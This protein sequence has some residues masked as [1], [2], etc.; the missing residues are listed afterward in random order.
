MK[1]KEDTISSFQGKVRSKKMP[2][3]DACAIQIFIATIIS[4]SWKWN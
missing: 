4:K 2:K 3:P 1:E